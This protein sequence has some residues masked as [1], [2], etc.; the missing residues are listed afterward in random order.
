MIMMAIRT[1]GLEY[2][3]RLRK[4]SWTLRQ[5]GY[6]PTIVAVETANIA[7]SGSWRNVVPYE[8]LSLLTR[9]FTVRGQSLGLK[10]MEMYVRVLARVVS[11]RPTVVWVHNMEMAGLLPLLFAL[12]RLRVIKRVVW[13]QHE[14][15]SCRVLGTSLSRAVLRML[16]EAC[17]AVV[18]ANDA[19]KEFLCEKLKMRGPQRM[20]VL[21]NYPDEEFISSPRLPLPRGVKEWLAGRDYFLGQGAA[22]K[23]RHFEPLVEAIIR[24]GSALVVVG[25]VTEDMRSKLQYRFGEP[26][27]EHVFFSGMV[28]QL[29]LPRYI[30]NALASIILYSH[31]TPN[32]KLCAPNRLYQALTRGV[33]V[34]VGNNPPMASI[35]REH[36]CGVVLEGDGR[37][38]EDIIRGLKDLV[39]GVEEYRAGACSVAPSVTWEVQATRV[40]MAVGTR[41]SPGGCR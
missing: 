37:D 33:P 27:N 26:L 28:P 36:R 20:L 16:M 32:G 1:S 7:R 11:R 40:E 34:L 22:L 19:R 18:V 14:L 15:P 30:D 9:S 24:I 17:D 29:E 13:D 12:R 2:D 38:V 5:L 39:A 31:R 21:D 6:Q 10:A 3:D 8:S 41:E 25:P 23:S 35:V 4:E